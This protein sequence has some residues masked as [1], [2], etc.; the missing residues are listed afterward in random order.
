EPI[1]MLISPAILVIG[2]VV[3]GLVPNVFN[4]SFLQHA[5]TSIHSSA[6]MD[7]ISYWHGLSTPFIMSLIV[8]VLGTLLFLTMTRWNRIYNVLPGN[9]S[10]NRLYDRSL[11]SIDQMSSKVTNFYMNGSVRTYMSLILGTMFVIS[12]FFMYMTNGFTIDFSDLASVTVLEIVVVIAII[13]AAIGT[14][15]SNNNVACIVILGITGYSVTILFVLYRAPDLA[16]T[17][18]V[19]ETITTTL[20]LLCF[21]HFP[22]LKKR[23]ESFKTK[24]V[25]LFIS[26]G[27]GALLTI[28]GLAAYGS[29]AFPKISEYSVVTSL[30]IGGGKNIVNVILVDMRGI[31]TLVA[32]TVLGIAGLT[33]F[34]LIKLRNDKEADYMEFIIIILSGI[35]VVTGVYNIL[36]KQLVRIAIGTGLI[37]HGAHL[38]IL[39]MGKLKRGQPPIIEEGITNYT[40]PLPHALILTSIVISFGV[41]SVVLVLAYRTINENKTDNMEQLRGNENE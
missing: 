40:D 35:V 39:T 31:D 3:I 28:V 4:Q 19:I 7:N 29:A 27:F 16:L 2:I 26:I 15:F 24:S 6:I 17:Q 18:L 37:S 33:V 30:P 10:F 21:Y 23:T 41:T 14:I 11:T 20:F 8:V 9:L 25:N 38:F 12:F 22:K 13:V 34:G 1:G 36:Q 5:A 32:V